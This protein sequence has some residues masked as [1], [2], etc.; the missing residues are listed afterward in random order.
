MSGFHLLG[1]VGTLESQFLLLLLLFPTNNVL[2]S[3]FS[4]R[5]LCGR[6]AG[7]GCGIVRYMLPRADGGGISRSSATYFPTILENLLYDFLLTGVF[8][9]HRGFRGA[10]TV[11]NR[12]NFMLQ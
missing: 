12:T 8:R 7:F 6:D 2:R 5:L 3:S 11:T 10:V 1:E 9:R 4:R